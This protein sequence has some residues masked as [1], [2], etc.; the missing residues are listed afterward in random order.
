MTVSD[1]H[2]T[3]ATAVDH[4]TRPTPGA[5]LSVAPMMAWTTPAQRYFMRCITRHALLYTEMVTTGALIHGDTARFLAYDAAEHPLA[6]QLGGSEPND[7]VTCAR[8]AEDAGFDEVNINVGC[9]SDRVQNGA[10]GACLMADPARVADCVNAMRAVVSIPVTVKTRIGIDHQDSYAF[11]HDFTSQ[12]KQAG[13]DHLTV[14]AR[15]AW[16]TGLSPKENRDVPPLDYERVYQLAADFA[17]LPMSINGGVVCL[18]A[19][20][21]HLNHVDGVMIGR[22]AYRN[23]YFMAQVDHAVFGD[24]TPPPTR[25]DVA[26]AMRDH[27]EHHLTTGGA[28]KDVSRH[29]LG[30]FHG[31]P[32]G[33]KWRRIL[34][35]NAHHPNAGWDVIEHALTAVTPQP[36]QAV[37]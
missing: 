20:Q 31:Q 30:L 29:M 35:E 5:R 33:K 1:F 12:M 23:P 28:L 34:S 3:A 37:A 25:Y 32:G 11:L 24:D 4:V 8:L 27:I 17:D 7:M 9:P 15:K 16:L 18:D 36:K 6:L 2:A 10:F 26:L 19:V 22:E 21:Q 14:H 13:A